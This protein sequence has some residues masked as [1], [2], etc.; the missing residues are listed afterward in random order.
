L[1]VGGIPGYRV[2]SVL[3]GSFQKNGPSKPRSRAGTVLE[4]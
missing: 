3:A 1:V 2:D 4:E